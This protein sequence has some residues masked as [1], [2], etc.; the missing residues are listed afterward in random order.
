M[1][2]RTDLVNIC[3]LLYEKGFV[4]ATEGNVSIKITADKIL[5][6]PTNTNKSHIKESDLVTINKNGVKV[7]GKG[8]PSAEFTLH[9][10]VYRLRPDV[11]AIIHAHPPNAVALSIAGVKLDKDILPEIIIALGEV[12][13][14]KYATATTYELAKSVSNLVR[15]HDAIIL[16]RHGTLTIGKNLQEAFEILERLEWASEVILKASLLGRVKRLSAE[17]VK[18]L[19][20]IRERRI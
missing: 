5:I 19:L 4:V 1:N 11:R 10:E 3:H 20:A 14:A 2:P 9:T 8:M 7:A 16:E 6:T 12:P 18:K 17:E 15:K 13:T